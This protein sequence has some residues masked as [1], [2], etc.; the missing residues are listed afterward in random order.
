MDWTQHTLLAAGMTPGI[1][2]IFDLLSAGLY[3]VTGQFTDAGVSAAAA[4]PIFGQGTTVAR[5]AHQGN[6]LQ[7]TIAKV[8]VK[9]G[10]FGQGPDLMRYRFPL[11]AGASMTAMS[12]ASD[13]I[14]RILGKGDPSPN[15]PS[16]PEI[17]AKLNALPP[18]PETPDSKLLLNLAQ[19][20]PKY[21]TLL[22]AALLGYKVMQLINS[23]RERE[24][25]ENV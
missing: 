6:K 16:Q 14:E 17:A 20:L 8:S 11:E 5:W 10:L 21:A 2:F 22:L 24:E 25:P 19:G 12:L 1:G 15:L 18:T 4:I 13:S 7:Q 23:H 9:K 3:T